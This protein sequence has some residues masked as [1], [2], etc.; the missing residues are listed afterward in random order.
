MTVTFDFTTNDGSATLANN[1]YTAAAGTL[2]IPAGHDD[3][4]DRRTGPW[5][6]RWWSRTRAFTV[7]LSNPSGATIADG[8]GLGTILNDDA[9]TLSIDDVS[10]AEGDA[11]TSD[12]PVHGQPVDDERQ[13]R[14]GRFRH[15]RRLG[16]AGGQ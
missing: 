10:L 11:G 15:Q 3:P 4:D 14:D 9:A 12:L 2:G 16:H 6:T 8:Q 13:R 5:A 7:D 1:D